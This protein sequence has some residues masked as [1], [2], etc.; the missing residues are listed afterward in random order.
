MANGQAKHN[1]D[2]L[3]VDHLSRV[4]TITGN[5]VRK[6]QAAGIETLTALATTSV[7][8]VPKLDDGVFQRLKEQAQ[9]QKSAEGNWTSRLSYRAS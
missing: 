8:H 9:L 7:S 3:R 1:T 2:S 6:L 4:A 5:Q